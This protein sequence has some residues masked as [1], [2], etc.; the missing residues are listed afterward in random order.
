MR[1]WALRGRPFPHLGNNA[2]AA[3]A[4]RVAGQLPWPILRTPYTRLG[5]AEGIP[6]DRLGD[7]DLGAVAQWLADGLPGA[8]SRPS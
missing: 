6:P 8:A 5:A 1:G 7:V 3:A 4:V 2:A